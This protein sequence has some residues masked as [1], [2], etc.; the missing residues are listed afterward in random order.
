[1]ILQFGAMEALSNS[2]PAVFASAFRKLVDD[3]SNGGARRVVIAGPSAFEAGPIQALNAAAANERLRTLIDKE[4]ETAG[5]ARLT[6]ADLFLLPRESASVF[7]T[8]DGVHLNGNGLRAAGRIIAAV[9]GVTDTD[10]ASGSSP[11][12]WAEERLL[13]AIRE[14]N[15]L[16][17]NYY[18]PQN[19]AFL[20]GD[21]TNQPSSRDYRVLS[22]RWFPDEMEEWLPLIAAKEAEISQLAAQA[23]ATLATP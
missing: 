17:F 20:A 22:K 18:R 13:T 2:E 6:F 4:K 9:M 7:L 1:M 21:R 23:H 5:T 11:R 16:W 8:R 19:W 14:K 10:L 15:R 12:A 3:V